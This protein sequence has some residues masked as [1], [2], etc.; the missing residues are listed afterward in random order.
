MSNN[1]E[2]TL[3]FNGDLEDRLRAQAEGFKDVSLG[4]KLNLSPVFTM[5]LLVEAA[6]EIK[7]L[8]QELKL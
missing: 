4:K 8:R 2:T 3:K 6:D 7:L 5:N 1:P